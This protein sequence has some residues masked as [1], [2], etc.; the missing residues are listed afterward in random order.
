MIDFI[1]VMFS[2][3]L[4]SGKDHVEVWLKSDVTL[5]I[6]QHI[7]KL[8]LFKPSYFSENV[9]LLSQKKIITA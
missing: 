4:T 6:T 5:D 7:L 2:A 3:W 8:L 9:V 1:I